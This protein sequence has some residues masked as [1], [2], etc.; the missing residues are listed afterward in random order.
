MWN[1]TCCLI[2]A[3]PSTIRLSI[4]NPMPLHCLYLYSI[5][6][7]NIWKLSVLEFGFFFYWKKRFS[8][9]FTNYN[10]NLQN[11]NFTQLSNQ[12]S[13]KLSSIQYDIVSKLTFSQ[14]TNALLVLCVLSS[15]RKCTQLL[16]SFLC[17]GYKKRRF[18][19]SIV[20]F[21]CGFFQIWTQLVS[22]CRLSL[23]KS[24]SYISNEKSVHLEHIR[25]CSH[26]IRIMYWY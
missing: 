24:H 26:S 23:T 7:S 6:A 21:F 12:L 11:V 1:W 5:S 18:V 22:M 10:S 2:W 15:I 17:K 19:V 14:N 8:F 20:L 3:F 13:V 16:T 9:P 25:S 4:Q